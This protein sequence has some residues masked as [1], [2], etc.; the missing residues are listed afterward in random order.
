MPKAP[1]QV[2]IDTE[3]NNQNAMTKHARERT[4]KQRNTDQRP[5][6]CRVYTHDMPVTESIG[7]GQNSQMKT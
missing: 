3:V 7:W 4:T 1:G 6:H 2:H 5:G